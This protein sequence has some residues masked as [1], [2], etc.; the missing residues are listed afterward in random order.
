MPSTERV[1]ASA[2]ELVREFSRFSDVALSQPVV[3]TQEGVPRNVLISYAE[4]ERLIERDIQAF[5][6]A[7]TPD[8]FLDDLTRL[9]AADH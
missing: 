2:A 1:L 3:V 9:A 7:D 4:Y 8:E 6:A 5:R